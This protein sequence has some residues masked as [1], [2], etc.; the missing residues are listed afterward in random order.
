MYPIFESH[1]HYDDKKLKGQ[2]ETLLPLVKE[3]GVGKIMNISADMQ[4]LED[5]LQL[6]QKYDFFYGSAG[7][8]PSCSSDIPKDYLD[9]VKQYASKEKI[10]AIGEIGL[11]F[12]YDFSPKDTQRRVFREQLELANELDMPVIIH[13]RDAHGEI[14]EILKEYKP[15]GVFHCYSG[16]AEFAK[17]VLKLGMYISFTGVITF[18]NAKKAVEAAK[19]IPLDRILIET[20]CPYMAPEPVRGTTN[21]SGNL[22]YIAKKLAEIKGIATQE[23]IDQTYL[24]TC[25]LFDVP[26]A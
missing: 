23:L 7:I 8:H 6:T 10:Q 24:N 13:D 17:E 26:V 15:K 18:K 1:A 25:K 11:D 20:D 2:L 14:L 19:I 22:P 12:H 21:H 4:S 5:T 3:A 9:I 16:S